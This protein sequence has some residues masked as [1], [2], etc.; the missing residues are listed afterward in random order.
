MDGGGRIEITV[1]G[2]LGDD[3]GRRVGRL[4]R[5][6]RGG[7]AARPLHHPPLPAARSR[8]SGS[9]GRGTGWTPRH[10]VARDRTAQPIAVMPLYAKSHSQ[11]EYIFDHNWAHAWERAGGSY[12]PKLQA[13]GAL[14]PGDRPALPDPP[15]PRGRGPRRA[16]AGRAGAGAAVRRLEPARHLLHRGRARL[17]RGGGPPRPHH[18][19]VP[20]AEPRLRRLRRLPR[21]PRLAQAQGDPQGARSARR[22]SAARSWR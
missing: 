11:G 22:P 18:P 13:R 19:A 14:H 2:G 7:R 8:H 20:L 9:V 17:G 3:R 5:R 1:L 12:Y 15:R 10:L 21:R 16:A 6:R 4:R